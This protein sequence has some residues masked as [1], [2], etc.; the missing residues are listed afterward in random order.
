MLGMGFVSRGEVPAETKDLFDSE[1]PNR[2]DP[3]RWLVACG[4]F[5]I[6]AIA[7]GTAMTISNFR[8]RALESGER[9]LQNTVLLLARHF[10]Q[11]LDDLQVPLVDLIGYMRA[12]GI[13]SPDDFK[14][15][16]STHEMHLLMKAKVSGASEIA[17]INIYDADGLL[18]NS[19]VVPAVPY[20]NIADRSYFKALKSNPDVTQ[21][22]IELVRSRFS[23]GWRTVIA[24]KV[25]GPDGQFIGV[26]SR[27]I[28]PAKFEDFFSTVALG[29]D[30]TISMH[31]RNGGLLGRYPHVETMIGRNFKI[32]PGRETDLLNSDHGAK[33]LISP[34]DGQERLAS[35]QA[36]R[37]FPLS[38]V[39][40]TTVASA[41]ADW[42]AQTKFL[43][44]AA[45]LSAMVIAV[46]LALIVRRLA[47][48]HRSSQRR[49]ALEK[50]RL[51]RIN[52]HFDAALSNMTQGLCM[53]DGQKR[54]VVWN[55]RYAQLYQLPP[56]L[57]KVGMPHDAIIADRFL[58]SIL[59]G[60]NSD[61]AA[62]AKISALGQL[63]KDTTSSRVDEFADGRFILVTRKPMADGGW[64]AT[65]EDITERRR[66]EAEIVHLARHDG[67]TGLANRAEFNARLEEASARLKRNGGAVTVMMLDL[68]KFKA[69]NDT[70][71]HLAG[72][73]LLVEVGRRLQS[74]IRETDVLARLGGDEFA[75]IQEG[76]PD[77]R[78]GATAL[79]LRI[80]SAITRPF[81]LSGHE[82]CVGISIGLAL[83]SV[84]GNESEQL[85]K[86]ADLALYDAKA[87]GRND[88]R[89][90]QDEMLKAADLQKLAESELRDAIAR[91]EFELHYQPVISVE[92]RTL[93]GAEALVRWRH[94]TRGL[95]PPDQFIP[96][97][98]STGLIVQLGEWVLRQACK[99]ASSW[100]AHVK[101][102]VN[103][104]AV[105]FRRGNLFDTILRIL[106][107]TGLPPDRLELEIT[108]TAL[109][110]N[111]EAHL[112]TIR[113][114]KS[115]G[116]SMALDDFGT[117]YSAVNY[118]TIFPFDKIKIDKSFTQ[119]V[120]NRRDCKAVIA[121]TLALA[122]GL[123]TVTTAEGIET[124]EQFEYLR[125]AGV[126]IAQGYLFGRPV[127]LSQLDLRDAALPNEPKSTVAKRYAV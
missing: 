57:L 51:E 32:G 118:L 90:F 97:A 120:L 11:Q 105:Q 73:Q 3:I 23:G 98:E 58:R 42:R 117:G 70:R 76:V 50:Q 47:W 89:V 48:Q 12:T 124:E 19:S 92:T 126:D 1:P 62:K 119:G 29:K 14:R 72:D 75:I 55:E 61:S 38:V 100:P 110:D 41:L 113:R 121:S 24:R 27:A 78:A 39:A 95:V 96:L 45:G 21:P 85:L 30:A 2:R 123:G 112:A 4:I 34:I 6:A 64:L 26:I 44:I 46:I 106:L 65:H 20:V 127:P 103:I 87:N 33:R 63:P 17:G 60:D 122:Q 22:Q 13:A 115:L 66:A 101:L 69:V 36:L 93:C 107:E 79:A 102:A 108:E 25:I 40:T 52:M 125:K 86:C 114:L 15:E 84:H 111:Q 5:L 8:E 81:D 53:F 116:I 49:L 68:D 18:I 56:E 91:E 7:V 77:Q 99:D 104:S 67:L 35:I 71:G 54:L 82:T 31:H 74:E 88:F 43:I 37:H 83:G 9:E 80:I 28:A 10:D 16:M 109:L 94:P 59:K